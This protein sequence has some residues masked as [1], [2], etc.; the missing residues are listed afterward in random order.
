[1]NRRSEVRGQ[2]TEGTSG[3][4]HPERFT[5]ESRRHGEERKI[6]GF[7]VFV[8]ALAG[9]KTRKQLDGRRRSD[10]VAGLPVS[11]P[12]S[13]PDRPFCDSSARDS[14]LKNRKTLRLRFPPCLRA[15]VVNSYLCFCS[16]D[17]RRLTL[18]ESSRYPHCRIPIP[19]PTAGSISPVAATRVGR[20][21]GGSASPSERSPV[22]M[23]P[24]PVS[25][26]T[27]RQDKPSTE[28]AGEPY[29]SQ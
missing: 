14:G 8:P 29:F 17:S 11:T 4:N 22:T 1:M 15:S 13:L 9:P 23:P 28:P 5:T 16:V 25:S 2:K 12:L 18:A 27:S 19:D 20:F 24:F 7:R 21:R 10:V 3:V 26:W 6:R